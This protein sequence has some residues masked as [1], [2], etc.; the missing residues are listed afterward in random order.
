MNYK[1]L[2]YFMAPPMKRWNPYLNLLNLG[3][4]VTCFDQDN[5][6]EIMWIPL[7]LDSRHLTAFCSCM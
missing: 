2:K 5:Q 7:V 6:T 4:S 3:L 1:W